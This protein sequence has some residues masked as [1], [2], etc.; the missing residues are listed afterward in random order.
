MKTAVRE[1]DM[2]RENA[3]RVDFAVD[4]ALDDWGE[5]L[6][7]PIVLRRFERFQRGAMVRHESGGRAE[8][9]LKSVGGE[10]DVGGDARTFL[11]SA[12]KNACKIAGCEVGGWYG[13][14]ALKQGVLFAQPDEKPGRVWVC[15]TFNEWRE[16]GVMLR[17]VRVRG[18]CT[19][20]GLV[21]LGVGVYEYRLKCDGKWY[22]DF[23]NRSVRVNVYGTLNH[24]LRVRQGY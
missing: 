11:R 4:D 12:Y 6:D 18:L 3:A 22:E 10:R 23:F 9:E 21:K 19:C 17:R 1:R 8:S 20:L 2:G 5:G 15:G 13:V 16:M 7:C 24:L 14:M